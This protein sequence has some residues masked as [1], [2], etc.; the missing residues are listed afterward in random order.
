MGGDKIVDRESEVP[1]L[2]NRWWKG[3]RGE[4]YLVIQAGLLL[5][6]AFGPRTLRGLPAWTSPYAWLGSLGGSVLLAAGI[7]FAATGAVNLGKNLTPL[8]QPKKDA[9]LITSGAYRFV[10]HPIY[11]GIILMAIG[12]GLWLH[13]WLNIGYAVLLFVFLDI[14][15]RREEKW[16]LEKFPEYAAYRKRVRKLIPFLY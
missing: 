16:L 2:Q 3:L 11:S 12:W 10:R 1:L 5:L 8:P 9:T 4:W 13:S 14:K 6:V 7:L 15:A